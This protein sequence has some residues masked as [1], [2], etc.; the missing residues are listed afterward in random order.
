VSLL[1]CSFL[2]LSF[3][4]AS[5]LLSPSPPNL[6]DVASSLLKIS[7]QRVL[8]VGIKSV[9]WCQSSCWRKWGSRTCCESFSN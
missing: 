1:S 6:C 9:S 7:F 8:N 2:T 5:H 4:R 3:S